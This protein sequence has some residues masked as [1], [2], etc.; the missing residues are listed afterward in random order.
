MKKDAHKSKENYLRR[1][2]K[3]SIYNCCLQGQVTRAEEEETTFAIKRELAAIKQHDI[4]T[5]QKLVEA[6]DR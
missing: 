6:R 4:D 5:N 1:M 2:P 3:S